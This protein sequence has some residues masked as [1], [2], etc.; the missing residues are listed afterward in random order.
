VNLAVLLYFLLIAGTGMPR[1]L[2][3]LA[4]YGIQ[5]SASLSVASHMLQAAF[6]PGAILSTY[7]FFRK[8]PSPEIFFFVFALVSFSLE[9]LRFIA[10]FVDTLIASQMALI[11]LT[12]IVYFSRMLA[13]LA[14]FASG[15]FAT[16]LTYQRQELYLAAFAMISFILAAALPID[17]TAYRLPFLLDAGGETGLSIA[18]YAIAVFA[19][20]NFF[21]AAYVHN[22]GNYLFNALAMLL[23]IG[24][25]EVFFYYPDTWYV[26]PALLGMIG[27]TL[28][29]AQKTHEIY[30]W[31]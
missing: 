7:L 8:T 1:F 24:A 13:I 11:P 17:F 25:K 26:V 10:P 31:L 23:F 9:S 6:V 3:M 4:D 5:H 29:F 30:L 27:G 15:L 19:V 2:A 20:L 14:L 16:G 21:Y 22:N 18:Y 12:R 28:L